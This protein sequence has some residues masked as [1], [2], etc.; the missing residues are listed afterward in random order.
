MSRWPVSLLTDAAKNDR[1]YGWDK[2]PWPL[3]LATLFGLRNRLREKNLYDTG[4]RPLD[5]PDVSDRPRYLTARI[6]FEVHDWFS[7]GKNEAS[8]QRAGV[9]G[10]S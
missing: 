10:A 4:R 6:Q 2:L 5:R 7:H 3:G 9:C 8:W 1:R